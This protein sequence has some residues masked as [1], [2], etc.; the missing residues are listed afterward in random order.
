[1]SYILI[2]ESLFYYKA[3]IEKSTDVSAIFQKQIIGETQ[4]YSLN[5]G[6]LFVSR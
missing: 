5:Q 2:D 6:I 1:M 3:D 4:G